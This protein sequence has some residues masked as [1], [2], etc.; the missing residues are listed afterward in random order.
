MNYG[1][2]LHLVCG[3]RPKRRKTCSWYWDHLYVVFPCSL[4][5]LQYRYCTG[6]VPVQASVSAT[7]CSFILGILIVDTSAIIIIIL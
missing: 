5:V 2:T 4:T 1:V 6:I 3:T 7:C